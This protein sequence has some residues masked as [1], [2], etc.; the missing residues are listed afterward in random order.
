LLHAL[1]VVAGRHRAGGGARWLGETL[2]GAGPA[3]ALAGRVRRRQPRP[4]RKASNRSAGPLGRAPEPQLRRHV[5]AGAAAAHAR[6]RC[7]RHWARTARSHGARPPARGRRRRRAR[8]RRGAA[9][10][11]AAAAPPVLTQPAAAEPLRSEADDPTA[12]AG[13]RRRCQRRAT[14]AATARDACRRL[15]TA[16]RLAP[17]DTIE[18]PVLQPAPRQARR[19]IAHPAPQP[20]AVS[21]A[22]PAPAPQRDQRTTSPPPTPADPVP[23]VRPLPVPAA[24]PVPA[25]AR[26]P[27]PG[28]GGCGRNDLACR[29]GR[30]RRAGRAAAASAGRGAVAAG[31][32]ATAHGGRTASDRPPRCRRRRPWRRS[33][34]QRCR[35]PSCLNWHRRRCVRRA[36]WACLHR[37]P[38]P[39]S[40]GTTAPAARGGAERLATP[41]APGGQVQR[42]GG[43]QF[44]PLRQRRG[45]GDRRH[46][47][48]RLAHLPGQRHLRHGGCR[49][50]GHRVQ[51]GQHAP[52]AVVEGQVLDAGAARALG[53]VGLAAVLAGEEAPRQ[54]EEVDHAQAFAHAQRLQ[55]RLRSRRG[56]PGCTAAA[57]SRSAAGPGGRWC[58]APRCSRGAVV[59][60]AD[61]AHLAG[62]IRSAKAPSVSSSG[63]AGVVVVW[64]W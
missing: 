47:A 10:T 26:A 4:R 39:P 58:P 52:A 11:P 31:R 62:A 28:A 1:L 6:T 54:A 55:R 41:S 56:R 60:G 46:D 20:A 7:R 36:P 42:G 43:G 34:P 53:Q 24:V 45:A 5:A 9:P 17:A 57:A 44:L 14:A 23:P 16:P 22:Q 38:P 35:V 12:T 59:A 63:V 50:G 64:A 40:P 32:G 3:S 13:A 27:A 30:A 49:A 15:S 25:A 48:V 37:G 2:L 61:G 33:T 21:R 51:R 18:A 8:G 19:D 29:T